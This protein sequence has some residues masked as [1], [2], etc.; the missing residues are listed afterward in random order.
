M[1]TDGQGKL[2]QDDCTSQPSGKILLLQMVR[3]SNTATFFNFTFPASRILFS[4]HILERRLGHLESFTGL[5]HTV[6]AD[7]KLVEEALSLWTNRSKWSNV[8]EVV[9]YRT[10][11]SDNSSYLNSFFAVLSCPCNCSFMS[12][13]SSSSLWSF[14]LAF[15]SLSISSSASST[16]RFIA[17]KRKLNCNIYMSSD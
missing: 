9:W 11:R 13:C 2:T 15:S 14:F 10:G 12:S 7:D 1:F 6:C 3:V 8:W 4:R 16:W 17:F 5:C